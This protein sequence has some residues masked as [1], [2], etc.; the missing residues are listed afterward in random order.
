MV[1]I[2][3]SGPSCPGFNSQHSQKN[4]QEQIV[5]V[6][7]VNQWRWLE[8]SGQWIKSVD[9]THQVYLAGGKLVQQKRIRKQVL[10]KSNSKLVLK[11]WLY[12]KSYQKV[13]AS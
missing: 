5:D 4:S 11:E 9:Q 12:A 7:E 6:A 10:Q 13:A 2:L 3:A 8:E 1:G